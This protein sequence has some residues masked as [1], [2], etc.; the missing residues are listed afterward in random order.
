MQ[1][2]AIT[3][4]LINQKGGVGKSTVTFN[5]GAVFAAAGFRTLL[6]DADPQGNL[7]AGVFGPAAIEQM[8]ENLSLAGLFSDRPPLLDTVVRATGFDNLHLLPSNQLLSRYSLPVEI[9]GDLVLSLG[10]FM[11]EAHDRFDVVLVDNAPAL[12][13]ISWSSLLATEHVIVPT[14][15]EDYSSQGLVQ[16]SRTVAAAQSHNPKLSVLGFLLTL[17]QPRLTV[18]RAYEITLREEYGAG[19]LNTVIKADKLH[20]EAIMERQP[21]AAYKPRSAAA[22]TYEALADEIVQRISQQSVVTEAA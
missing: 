18:H 8:S 6:I 7:S 16:V 20:K 12:N 11:Q 10:N 1:P 2:M 19:V 5:L 4:S 17:V 9:A 22:K 14:I 3:F 21:L 15:P 13:A